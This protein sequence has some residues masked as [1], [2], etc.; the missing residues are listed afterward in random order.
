M[1]LYEERACFFSFLD[2][3]KLEMLSQHFQFLKFDFQA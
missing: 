1:K 3:K 2:S